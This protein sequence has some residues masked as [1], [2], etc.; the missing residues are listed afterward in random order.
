MN[1]LYDVRYDLPK[2]HTPALF[3]HVATHWQK[4]KVF[5]CTL[6]F[7]LKNLNMFDVVLDYE[8]QYEY[9]NELAE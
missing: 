3:Q 7:D 2:N 4:N 8:E 6:V 9:G 5:C 1:W